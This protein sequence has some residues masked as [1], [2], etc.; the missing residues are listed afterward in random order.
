MTQN[1]IGFTAPSGTGK[2]TLL[3]KII[4]L[5]V[6]AG[7]K[8]AVLKHGH[9]AADPDVPGKDTWR[10]RKAGAESVIF[11]GPDRWFMICEQGEKE[12]AM[13]LKRL[14][15]HDLILIEGLRDQNHPKLV[16]H[17]EAVT[18]HPEL[19]GLSNVMA[20]VSDQTTLDVGLPVLPLNEP[21]M[22][23]RFILDTFN[24]G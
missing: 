13:H 2:T 20:V 7:L 15:G 11:S 16:L 6:D 3:E 17:R 14:E 12:P 1:I 5:L 8:V 24:D 4:P 23:C 19:E 18:K 21:E 9:H 22:V 10:F